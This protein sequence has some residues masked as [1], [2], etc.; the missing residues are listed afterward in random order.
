MWRW[1][2]TMA[3]GNPALLESLWYQVRNNRRNRNETILRKTK[4]SLL[5][6]WQIWGR[7]Q[8]RNLQWI[9]LRKPEKKL[10]NKAIHKALQRK[11]N[12]LL[13]ST[14]RGRW[15]LRT[16]TTA[17]VW[18]WLPLTTNFLKWHVVGLHV[19]SCELKLQIYIHLARVT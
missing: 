7:G 12:Q 1:S 16:I 2:F 14:L 19:I 8:G 6:S 10:K 3:S 4:I 5:F 15:I 13:K 18:L 11:N 9:S 17:S